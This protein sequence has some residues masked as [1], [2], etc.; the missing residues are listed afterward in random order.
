MARLYLLLVLIKQKPTVSKPAHRSA[1]ARPS[2]TRQHKA[3]GSL[4]DSPLFSIIILVGASITTASAIWMFAY[5]QSRP[6]PA[7][8][9]ALTEDADT[10]KKQLIPQILTPA[11]MSTPS[12]PIVDD[13]A[14]PP[15]EDGLAP[16]LSTIPTTQPVVFL[17][18]DDGAFRDPSVV[19]LMREQH[20]HAS[21]FLADSFLGGD[22]AFFKQLTELGSVVEPHTLRHDTNMAVK[23]YEY[24][25]AE[26][27][28][29]ADIVEQQYGRRPTLFRPPGGGYSTTMR[30][31]A[32]DCGMKAI[33][34]WIAKA[35][36]GSMQYQYGDHL[37]PGDIV[38]MHFRPEFSD[39]MHAFLDAVNAAGLRI[40]LLESIPGA[41]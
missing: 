6:D 38:L 26:I 16:V 39:D 3:K 35:N 41:M 28:G 5:Y 23:S 2:K 1:R 12:E 40:E 7:P 9:V 14:I 20:I 34:T 11:I 8:I 30:R 25:K 10:P 17:G 4:L 37:Q 24:Q 29:M 22:Y 27:C 18:I 33:I 36:G 19:A 21:L 15:A 13:Y 31:A 32:H